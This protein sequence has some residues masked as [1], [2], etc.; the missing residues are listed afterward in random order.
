MVLPN[1]L[2]CGAPKAGTTALYAIL[3]QHPDICMSS[4]KETDFFQHNYCKGLL[5]LESCFSHY[6]GEKAIGEASPGNMI[7]PLAAERILFHIPDA[8]IIL[9]LRDPVE[10]AYSQYW[11]SIM[12]GLQDPNIDFSSI[13]RD[14]ENSWGRRI[15]ELGMYGEQISR[16]Q[17][18][19]PMSQILIL[20]FEDFKSSPE[21]TLRKIYGFLEIEKNFNA[22]V[23]KE[24]YTKYP[25]NFFLYS[26]LYS[27]WR[28]TQRLI[29]SQLGH[30]PIVMTKNVRSFIRGKLFEFKNNSTTQLS[31]EDR[32]YLSSVYASS[33]KYLSSILSKDLS[34][35]S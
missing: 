26:K 14:P 1:F 34:H 27:L 33:N 5:W 25:R 35:W 6:S 15:I 4:I 19:F 7:H 31:E 22:E 16:Y 18:H 23:N 9:I 32:K 30:W 17:E 20:F 21:S 2:I 29:E 10:R 12:L 11:H 13:I 3:S 24:N 28:P 8:K